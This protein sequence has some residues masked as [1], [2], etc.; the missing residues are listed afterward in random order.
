MKHIAMLL[1]LSACTLDFPSAQESG[2]Y[3]CADDR[4][5]AA[6]FRCFERVCIAAGSCDAPALDTEV[7]P[8]QTYVGYSVSASGS[9]LNPQDD[10]P[11]LLSWWVCDAPTASMYHTTDATGCVRLGD[12]TQITFAP[13]R[14]GSYRL[15]F[16]ALNP[17]GE[18][19]VPITV[20]ALADA[21]FAEL[22]FLDPRPIDDFLAD[23]L[24][25]EPCHTL[26]T[27]ATCTASAAGCAFDAAFD[28]CWK[29]CAALG[30]NTA[31]S[32]T[33]D[34]CNWANGVGPCVST[35]TLAMAC[36]LH[37]VT[38]CTSV[39]GCEVIA[40]N[41]RCV[42]ICSPF[43][44][45]TECER[46]GCLWDAVQ[47]LC[48][49]FSGVPAPAL[50]RAYSDGSSPELLRFPGFAT[51]YRYD[52]NGVFVDT[53][54]GTGQVVSS[55]GMGSLGELGVAAFGHRYFFR[56]PQASGAVLCEMG[57]NILLWQQ[58][59]S[60]TPAVYPLVPTQADLSAAATSAERYEV[61][62]P[63]LAARGTTRV[64]LAFGAAARTLV[65]PDDLSTCAEAG[66]PT[67]Y[68]VL[69]SLIP[70]FL[71]NTFEPLVERTPYPIY[72]A[73][74]TT[75]EPVVSFLTAPAGNYPCTS[76]VDCGGATCSTTCATDLD[77]QGYLPR[78]FAEG[79]AVIFSH[80]TCGGAYG[81]ACLGGSGSYDLVA[82]TVLTNGAR[83]ELHDAQAVAAD[84]A[85][86]EM[87][88]VVAGDLYG[89]STLYY[90]GL[91]HVTT[92]VTTRTSAG[93]AGNTTITY[94]IYGLYERELHRLGSLWQVNPPAASIASAI[95]K[96][97]ATPVPGNEFSEFACFLNG[98]QDL[99]VTS[100]YRLRNPMHFVVSPDGQYL[101]YAEVS[102][103]LVCDPP[104]ISFG[105]RTDKLSPGE[106]FESRILVVRVQGGA[107]VP[108]PAFPDLCITERSMGLTSVMP[109]FIAAG[110]QLVFSNYEDTDGS[111][112]TIYRLNLEDLGA[113]DCRLVRLMDLDAA[114][115]A[116]QTV[117]PSLVAVGV[118]MQDSRTYLRPT[119]SCAAGAGAWWV[120]GAAFA[121]A[122]R[123]RAHRQGPAGTTL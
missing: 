98:E 23:M 5:C 84:P 96:G 70:L 60:G 64:R 20:N 51:G 114:T 99:T 54:L 65:V 18:G 13:D 61:A 3:A 74:R 29:D 10:C 73:E 38:T 101:A 95:F 116:L 31:C 76:D 16:R 22:T 6:G 78:L 105:A 41:S 40:E 62:Y 12:T 1:P 77:V 63:H 49:A 19:A 15:E 85:L 43:V 90:L 121:W 111:I 103:D 34:I 89:D 52:P 86:A 46:N 97:S 9:L 69:F 122:R 79:D 4:D 115:E 17:D 57:Q 28:M 56:Q 45:Q 102:Q 50:V 32:A 55:T 39:S 119:A 93:I 58:D 108:E 113:T 67:Q 75:G 87:D 110:S 107:P 42:A 82:G 24:S 11:M 71:G 30:D 8:L 59:A 91:E 94:P 36:M 44:D 21:M 112:G 117:E 35:A 72:A 33:G 80:V 88:P 118:N 68:D 7:A 100:S 47:T 37:D 14:R 53:R 106:P 123:R 25:G 92:S 120:L 27:Q 66:G 109:F 2:R 83:L 81:V 104:L 48:A 26:T